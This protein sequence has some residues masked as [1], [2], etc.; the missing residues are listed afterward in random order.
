M[1]NETTGPT[2]LSCAGC[3]GQLTRFQTGL[4][5]E[6][7]AAVVEEHMD[8][9]PNC[10]LFSDQI[11]VVVDFVGSG[12]PVEVPESISSM[13]DDFATTTA[14]QPSDTADIVRSLCRLADS[15]DPHAAEDLVQ[16]TLLTALEDDTVGLELSALAQSLTDRAFGEAGPTL[17]SLDDYQTRIESLETDPDPDGDTAALFYPDFYASG[18]DAGRHVDA[19]NRW[20]RSNTLSPDDDVL[21]AGLYGVVDDAIAGLPDPLGQLVQL[22][23]ID[24]VS[25]PDAAKMLRLDE[26]H[27]VDALHRARVHLRSVVDQFVTVGR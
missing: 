19:P 22:V 7:D 18:P 9:C 12:Q 15:L 25:V 17:R 1:T 26:N 3:A 27:A 13:L 8:S 11:D 16:Q 24:D 21:T 20:G 14:D 6:A 4:L 10:R 5:E 23:D 2:V